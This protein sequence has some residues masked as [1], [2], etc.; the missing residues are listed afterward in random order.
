MGNMT[1]RDDPTLAS[2]CAKH[3]D[4]YDH[5]DD[6]RK[7]EDPRKFDARVPDTDWQVEKQQR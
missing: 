6:H 3:S 7:L 2:K 1:L 4:E 5:L